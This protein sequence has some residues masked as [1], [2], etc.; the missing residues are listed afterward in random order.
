[1][2]LRVNIVMA[3]VL[4]AIGVAALVE[5]AVQGGGQLGFLVGLA[6]IALGVLRWRAFGRP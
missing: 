3:V 6:F 4:I 5:T 1:V 2:L